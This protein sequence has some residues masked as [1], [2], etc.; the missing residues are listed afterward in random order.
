M[1]LVVGEIVIT[2]CKC[3]DIIYKK[4]NRWKEL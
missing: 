2:T 1:L 4:V 3:N